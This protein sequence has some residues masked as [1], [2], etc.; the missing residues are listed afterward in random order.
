[1]V[2]IGL[3]L[4]LKNNTHPLAEVASPFTVL[5]TESIDYATYHVCSDGVVEIY[6]G[7][8]VYN[9]EMAKR[10]TDVCGEII[11]GSKMLILGITSQYSD[12]EAE[13]RHFMSTPEALRF[14]LAEAYVLKSVSQRLLGN[15][16]I[17]FQRPPVPTRLFSNVPEARQWLLKV[18]LKK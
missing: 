18:N 1:M 3:P 5:R 4:H 13:A 11:G 8:F 7:D 2:G 9:L 12:I 6:Y 17:R 10:L 14:S 15:F 16:Y